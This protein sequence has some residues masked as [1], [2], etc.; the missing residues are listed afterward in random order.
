MKH[1]DLKELRFFGFF[2]DQVSLVPDPRKGNVVPFTQDVDRLS[3]NG[4]A[5]IGGSFVLVA[6]SRIRLITMRISEVFRNFLMRGTTSARK[7]ALLK[8][9]INQISFRPSLIHVMYSFLFSRAEILSLR[10]FDAVEYTECFDNLPTH[11]SRCSCKVTADAGR[12]RKDSLR[13]CQHNF[14]YHVEGQRM[15]LKARASKVRK[16]MEERRAK[17]RSPNPVNG[18]GFFPLPL[19]LITC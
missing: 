6:A 3:G 1:L 16:V 9:F 11:L 8:C 14:F 7:V 10:N 19:T 15:M 2:R 12:P 5:M 18:Q 13:D 4:K 17:R